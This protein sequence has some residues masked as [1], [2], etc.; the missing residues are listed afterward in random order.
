MP[1]RLLR[2]RLLQR[3]QRKLH[4]QGG[5][6][7]RRLRDPALPHVLPS[8]R[9]VRHKRRMRVRRA[10]RR[11]CVRAHRG[12]ACSRGSRG[13]GRRDSAGDAGARRARRC[14][15]ASLAAANKAAERFQTDDDAADDD[16]ADADASA[17]ATATVAA[18]G[19]SPRLAAATTSSSSL[20]A[21]GCAASLAAS[22]G[23]FAAAASGGGIG[24][25]GAP[26]GPEL[27]P[28]WLR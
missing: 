2:P 24:R 16:D 5:L 8:P 6:P 9:H 15:S 12:G 14:G 13:S 10:I 27:V 28:L 19:Y 18:A 11:H 23:P 17:A 22:R 25:R 26:R 21:A 7:G 1:T 4:V 20:H 3:E